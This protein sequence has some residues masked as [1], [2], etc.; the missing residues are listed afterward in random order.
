[1]PTVD[2][3]IQDISTNI[4]Y[5]VANQ[6]VN[7]IL[8][9]IGAQNYFPDGLFLKSD[10][11]DSS[12]TFNKENNI[13]VSANRCDVNYTVDYNP[14]ETKWDVFTFRHT[15]A[16]GTSPTNKH[17]FIPMF[18]DEA[19][20]FR[21]IE[22][23]VPCSIQ[24][25]FSMQ[26]KNKEHAYLMMSAIQNMY[27][28]ASVFKYH[29]I[30]YEYPIGYNLFRLIYQIY[31]MRTSFN[32]T[33]NFNSYLIEGTRGLYNQ[34][35]AKDFVPNG[36]GGITAMAEAVIKK[37]STKALGLLEFTQTR[38]EVQYENRQPD[39]FVVNFSYALQFSRPDALR[40]I[41][42]VVVENKLVPNFMV[43]V[44]P[45]Q[46]T[47]NLIGL[48]Q[49]KGLYGAFRELSPATPVVLKFPYYDDWNI[50]NFNM[51]DRKYYFPFFIANFTLDTNEDGS[52]A[53]S[54]LID[55]QALGTATIHPTAIA[56]MILHGSDLLLN[57][58]LFNVSVFV[59]D[60]QL[61]PSLLSID[62][63]LKLTINYSNPIKRYHLVIYENTKLDNLN[64][65]WLDVII[66]N[67]S[68]FPMT[69]IRNLQMFINKKIFYI[70]NSNK[71]L[72]FIKK[73]IM[74]K[75][76]FDQITTLITNGH[77]AEWAYFYTRTESQFADF[78]MNYYSLNT[79][80]FLYDEYVA[81]L[82][83]AGNITKGDLSTGYIRTKNGFPILGDV[84]RSHGFNI[85]LRVFQTNINVLKGKLE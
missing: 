83:A 25:E 52:I 81:Q 17:S 1:M 14:S 74:N 79:G 8:Q 21:I 62:D 57:T 85:P 82:I 68:F 15:Q 5:N 42:P 70:D 51:I 48:F 27:L 60:I 66:G 69:V 11:V 76:I 23:M 73:S 45:T 30:A 77:T 16:Y 28:K 12:I 75:S 59:N 4:I 33:V 61:D 58:G 7:S 46:N 54:T 53:S 18:V 49:E 78:L 63:T 3:L 36:Q 37:S 71:L 55:L 13:R 31:S 84:G 80:K 19:A 56:I 50:P 65:K 39:R 22:H 43:A 6:T 35:V 72:L 38:P 44:A 10:D 2:L 41:F 26:F 47:P 9:T 64:P 67:R 32:S 20:D 24:F 40:C 29:D 34:L